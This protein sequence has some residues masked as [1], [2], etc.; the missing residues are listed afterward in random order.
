MYDN[1]EWRKVILSEVLV[2]YPSGGNGGGRLLTIWWGIGTKS[3]KAIFD[4][5]CNN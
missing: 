4:Q 2:N 3:T 1:D 5:Y